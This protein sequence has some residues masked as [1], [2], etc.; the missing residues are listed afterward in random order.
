MDSLAPTLCRLF[1]L[2][3]RQRARRRPRA[4][5]EIL[6][7]ARPGAGRV[8]LL[9]GPSGAGKTSLLAQLRHSIECDQVDLSRVALPDRPTID[10]VAGRIVRANAD[11]ETIESGIVEALRL[12]SAVGLAEARD[13][14]RPPRKLSA[15]Q[16]FRLRLAMALARPTGESPLV[17]VGDEFAASLDDLTA[18][19]VSRCLRR[20][21]DARRSWLGAIVATG[22]AALRP[23]LAPDVTVCCDFDDW[24]TV[25]ASTNRGG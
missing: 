19:V 18:A 13:Y 10:C 24:R 4:S 15:G 12:L 2:P 14:L 17:L 6:R 23:A 22:R 21:V 7:A 3:E 9:T 5:R 8:I 16:R 11:D 1:D 20:A 25:S